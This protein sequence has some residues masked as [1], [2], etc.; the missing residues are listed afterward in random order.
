MAVPF[1]PELL[2][3]HAAQVRALA[4]RVVFDAELAEE[5]EQET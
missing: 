4:R 1:E 5:V 2:L 3:Q